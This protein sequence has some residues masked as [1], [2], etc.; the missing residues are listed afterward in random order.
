MTAERHQTGWRASATAVANGIDRAVSWFC[1]AVVIVV[2]TALLGMLAAN[3]GARYVLASGGFRFAQELP[4]RLFPVFIMAG[5]VL[6]VVRGGHMAVETILLM[7]D[8]QGAR[9]MLLAGHA[10]VIGSYLLLGRDILLLADM[11]WVDRSPVMGIP[12]SYGYYTLAIGLALV[13]IVTTTQAIRVAALGP[14]AM[15]TPGPEELVS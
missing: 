9:I 14:E 6:G 1:E 3:V 11:L 12:A 4:E 15:P 5:V 7:L 10:I 13:I 8:R 2:G